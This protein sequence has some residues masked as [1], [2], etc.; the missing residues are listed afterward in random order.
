MVSSNNRLEEWN[1]IKLSEHIILKRLLIII[2][3]N[4]IE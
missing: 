4:Q 1:Q 2:I 3:P